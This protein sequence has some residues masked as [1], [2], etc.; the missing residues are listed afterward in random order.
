[1]RLPVYSFIA[2]LAH[3]GLALAQSQK[4][5][6][7]S[8]TAMAITGNIT[9][10]DTRIVFENGE[11]I[12]IQPLSGQSSGIY[13][14]APPSN[15][16]LKNGNRLCG[17]RPP[18]FI[19][20]A[21]ALGHDELASSSELHLKIFIG[22]EVP[23]ASAAQGMTSGGAGFCALMNYHR[24]DLPVEEATPQISTKPSFDC[25]LA[26][27]STERAI[28]AVP[29]LSQLDVELAKSFTENFKLADAEQQT[30]LRKSQRAWISRRNDCGADIECIER[31]YR[32]RIAALNP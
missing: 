18:T 4:W 28:C 9:V 15:P 13:R 21:P 3:C 2:L 25:S 12:G 5:E 22:E 1:M 10:E 24:M 30:A 19:V 32:E 23:P 11:A 16:E 29:L 7:T 31:L 6:A 27:N 26:G 14:V 17:E 20:L 8:T